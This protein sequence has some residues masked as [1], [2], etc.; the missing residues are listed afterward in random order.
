M[1][2]LFTFFL[3][4]SFPPEYSSWKDLI[5]LR[6]MQNMIS[7]SILSLNETPTPR[8][9]HELLE[10]HHQSIRASLYIRFFSSTIPPFTHGFL[11]SLEGWYQTTERKYSRA[12]EPSVQ[13]CSILTLSLTRSS[14]LTKAYKPSSLNLSIFVGTLPSSYCA[15]TSI[16]WFDVAY[17]SIS[18]K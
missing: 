1:H 11:R 6:A 16:T 8:R 18:G 14:P 4:G 12:E 15:W 3:L 13:R 2:L 10:L 7:G 17:N 5:I 9:N